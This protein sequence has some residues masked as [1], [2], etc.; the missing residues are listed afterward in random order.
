MRGLPVNSPG[1]ESPAIRPCLHLGPQGER[2]SRPARESSFCERH[3]PDAG[4]DLGKVL[5]KRL[6]A[7]FALLAVLWPLVVRILHEIARRLR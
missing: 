5:A 3:D 2:C 6:W 7:V 1:A 4:F